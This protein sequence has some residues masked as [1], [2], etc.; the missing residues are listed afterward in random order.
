[1]P[2]HLP[3]ADP[4]LAEAR[5]EDLVAAARD[6][7]PASFAEL[8][9]RYQKMAGTVARRAGVAHEDADDV[10]AE[11]YTKLLRALRGG[12]GPSENF[13]G[14]LATAVRRVAWA[15][16]ED[17][18]H[19]RPTDDLTLLD[20]ETGFDPDDLG[21]S[22]AGAALAALPRESRTLLW[23]VEV[24]GHRIGDIALD[25]GKSPNSVSAA[26]CRARKRLRSEYVRRISAA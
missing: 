15:V 21:D 19:Y 17:A 13:P 1:M 3:D 7:D 6:G 5:D 18:K 22:V 16:Q 26:A 4:A 14:Y 24:E 12:R 23:R 11:A 25:L 10:V 20:V 2:T 8:Y 9:R